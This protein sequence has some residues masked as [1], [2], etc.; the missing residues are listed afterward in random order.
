MAA[1]S[2]NINCF[3]SLVGMQFWQEMNTRIESIQRC[4]FFMINSNKGCFEHVC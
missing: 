3:L 4:L 2:K 1:Y